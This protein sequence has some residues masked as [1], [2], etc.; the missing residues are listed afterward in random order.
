M[1]GLFLFWS[2]LLLIIKCLLKLLGDERRRLLVKNFKVS[3]EQKQACMKLKNL[4]VCVFC[5]Y[6]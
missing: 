5:L 1:Y 6:T 3:K 4:V 2:H